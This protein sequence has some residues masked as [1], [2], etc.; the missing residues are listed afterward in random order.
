MQC[1]SQDD[2]NHDNAY[3]IQKEINF[4]KTG[5]FLIIPCKATHKQEI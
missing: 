4:F 1:S 5:I 3:C 2:N